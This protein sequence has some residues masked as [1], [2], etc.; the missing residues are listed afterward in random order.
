MT[1]FLTFI[2]DGLACFYTVTNCT[3]NQ[4]VYDGG[5]ICVAGSKL[6]WVNTAPGNLKNALRSIYDVFDPEY[7]HCYLTKFHYRVNRRFDFLRSY[8]PARLC[9]SPHSSNA[10]KIAE[11]WLDLDRI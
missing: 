7:T 4:I 10:G 3:H 6:C 11:T 1:K 5:R 2:P 9:A 8:S